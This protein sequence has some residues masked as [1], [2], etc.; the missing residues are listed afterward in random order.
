MMTL[1]LT[2]EELMLM[3]NAVQEHR[4]NAEQPAEEGDASSQAILK[5]AQPLLDRLDAIFAAA[6]A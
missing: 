2:R 1:E 5:T 4:D 6:A 3:W